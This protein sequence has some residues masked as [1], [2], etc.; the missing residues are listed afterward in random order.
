MNQVET[1][2]TLELLP[3]WI[4]RKGKDYYL[5]R[6]GGDRIIR[7][8]GVGVEIVQLLK[9]NSHLAW[10]LRQLEKKYRQKLEIGSFLETLQHGRLL[11]KVNGELAEPAPSPLRALHH[12]TGLQMRWVG[13]YLCFLLTFLTPS[14][15]MKLY[16]KLPLRLALFFLKVQKQTL[17]WRQKGRYLPGIAA[18]MSALLP[19]RDPKQIK[20]LAKNALRRQMVWDGSEKQMFQ[21]APVPRILKWVPTI[22]DASGIAPLAAAQKD[23][24]GALISF[25]HYGPVHLIPMVLR[26]LPNN[27][28]I[29]VFGQYRGRAAGEGARVT[30]V[31]DFS[32]KGILEIVRR[33]S[34]G[35]LVLMAPDAHLAI[36]GVQANEAPKEFGRKAWRRSSRRT[37]RFFEH[38]VLGFSGI[39][40]LVRQAG[41][42]LFEATIVRK[43]SSRVHLQLDPIISDPQGKQPQELLQTLFDRSAEAILERPEEWLNWTSFPKTVVPK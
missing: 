12:R 8:N 41:C 10:V 26:C 6:L 9:R 16:G 4:H 1:F 34:A 39:E 33:L 21:L 27:F 15:L 31:N 38:Q 25:F 7:T 42:P 23:G 14:G 22:S 35:Q 37:C 28:K 2:Q 36:A 11:H 20:D 30:F 32:A 40:W 5:H 3:L 13:A 29:T 24:K 19:D 43:K 17:Y 18:N